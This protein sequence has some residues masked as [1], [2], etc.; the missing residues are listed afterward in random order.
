MVGLSL[1]LGHDPARVG[2]AVAAPGARRTAACRCSRCRRRGPSGAGRG[3]PGAGRAGPTASRIAAS[4]DEPRVA[5]DHRGPISQIRRPE[6]REEERQRPREQQREQQQPDR[7]HRDPD[8][9]SS[10]AK[11]P[12]RMSLTSRVNR[13]TTG[14]VPSVGSDDWPSR[15]IWRWIWLPEGRGHSLAA[16][17]I[18]RPARLGDHAERQ[19]QDRQPDGQQRRQRPEV[20]SRGSAPGRAPAGARAAPRGAMGS[21]CE[22]LRRDE[23]EQARSP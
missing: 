8:R 19:Q 3:L 4:D 7:Q 6:R 1:A 23:R 15:Y 5:V 18:A 9:W 16:S 17:A 10:S 11:R 12:S 20:V 14:P 21:R 22:W 13:L 2:V